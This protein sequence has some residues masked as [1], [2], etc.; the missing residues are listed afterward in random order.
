MP[1]IRSYAT[2]G[3]SL[4]AVF[5]AGGAAGYFVAH[6]Q[7]VAAIKPAPVQAGDDW[8]IVAKERLAK[9]L[10]LDKKQRERSDD[11]LADTAGSILQERERSMFTVHLMMLKH[12]DLLAAE[13]GLLTP[14]QREKLLA[15]KSQLRTRILTRFRAIL[16]SEPHAALEL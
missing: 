8:L 3:L 1:S 16:E 14:E 4:A 2:I 15:A 5:A 9:E 7:F 10:Q 6:R 11:L 12:H 13:P